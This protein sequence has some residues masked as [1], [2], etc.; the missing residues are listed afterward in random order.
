MI[1]FCKGSMSWGWYLNNIPPLCWEV[2]A[3]CSTGYLPS[4]HLGKTVSRFQTLL[5][6]EQENLA[7][8]EA[9]APNTYWGHVGRREVTNAAA[10]GPLSNWSITPSFQHLSHYL[11][12][13]SWMAYGIY[14][15]VFIVNCFHLF[16][17]IFVDLTFTITFCIHAMLYSPRFFHVCFIT[18]STTAG[19]FLIGSS[20]YLLWSLPFQVKMQVKHYYY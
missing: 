7:L 5:C 11:M 12:G 2:V 8:Q 19:S 6:R 10:V 17:F 15:A 13:F 20:F 3:C 16:V 4:E 14:S 1:F 9:A 18:A